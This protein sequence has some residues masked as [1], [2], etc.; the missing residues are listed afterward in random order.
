M[1]PEWIDPRCREIDADDAIV[2]AYLSISVAE[3]SGFC[4]QASSDAEETLLLWQPFLHQPAIVGVESAVAYSMCG[5]A[6]KRSM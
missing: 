3:S 4:G 2:L 5:S 1:P 6:A